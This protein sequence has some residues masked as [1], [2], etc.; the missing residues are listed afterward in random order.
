MKKTL[1]AAAL[2]VATVPATAALNVVATTS[3]MGVLVKAVAGQKPS[4]LP[5]GA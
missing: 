2:L 5:Q 1:L 3:S 4:L